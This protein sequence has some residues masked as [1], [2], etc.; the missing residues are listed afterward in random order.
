[1]LKEHGAV[2]GYMRGGQ[3][4]KGYSATFSW[5]VPGGSNTEYCHDLPFRPSNVP[6]LPNGN[7]TFH[8]DES[9]LGLPQSIVGVRLDHTDH[10]LDA[11]LDRYIGACAFA[12][13][14]HSSLHRTILTDQPVVIDPQES[15]IMLYRGRSRLLALSNGVGDANPQP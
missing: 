11:G 2:E 6:W 12:I 3:S 8:L 5:A 4:N 13:I 15:K 14:R 7:I 10:A 1:M 9:L